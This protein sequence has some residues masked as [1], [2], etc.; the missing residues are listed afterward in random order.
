MIQLTVTDTLQNF[1]NNYVFETQDDLAA[2]VNML[3]D[4]AGYTEEHLKSGT[5]KLLVKSDKP[6]DTSK[7][8]YYF[9]KE[10]KDLS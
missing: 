3:F 9:R 2:A 5:V 7:S 4:F 10:R 6:L 1:T 8:Y